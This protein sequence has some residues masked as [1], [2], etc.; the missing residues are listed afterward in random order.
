MRGGPAPGTRPLT[1]R[2]K[3]TGAPGGAPFRCF[4]RWLRRVA[5]YLSIALISSG[6]LYLPEYSLI[7]SVEAKGPNVSSPCVYVVVRVSFALSW[8]LSGS[9]VPLSLTWKISLF[10]VFATSIGLSAAITEPS[11]AA[12]GSSLGPPVP[13]L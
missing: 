6:R 2:R 8:K 10:S 7:D 4:R 5:V 1:Q 11:T 9:C 12:F 13:H 3:K